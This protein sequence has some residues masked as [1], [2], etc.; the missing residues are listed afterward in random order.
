MVTFNP[1]VI[2]TWRTF[3]YN[4]IHVLPLAKYGVLRPLTRETE[5]RKG[6]IIQINEAGLLQLHNDYFLI[7]EKNAL[8]PVYVNRKSTSSLDH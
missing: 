3:G 4:F 7:K 5:V 2:D 1:S 6:F 8:S